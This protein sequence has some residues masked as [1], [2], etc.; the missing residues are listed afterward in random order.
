[1]RN[2]VEYE[3]VSQD[4]S[5]IEAMVTSVWETLTG[6]S[7]HAASPQKLFIQWVTS[8]IV[9][10][11]ANINYAANQNIPSRAEGENL[12]ALGELFYN[13]QR[14]QAKY[15]HTTIRVYISEAQTVQVLIPSGTRF[16]TTDGAVVF[17]T[18]EDLYV[19]PGDIYIDVPA[20]CSVAGTTGNGY[21]P[22][23]INTCVDV[24]NLYQSCSNITTTDG[25]T[26]IATDDEYYDVLVASMDAHSTAGASASY[27]YWSKQVSN[28]ILD[29]CV[30][31]PTP[32]D[33]NIY[34]IMS[35]GSIA[36]EEMKTAIH[37]A[38]NSDD[39]RPLT[40]H[41]YVED[42]EIVEYDVDLTYYLSSD[43]AEMSA[44][45]MQAKVEEVVGEYNLWQAS[46]IGRDINPSKLIHMLMEAGVKRVDVTSPVFTRLRSGT[47]TDIDEGH[48]VPQLA[49][50]RNINIVSGGYEDE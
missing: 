6:Q 1:M 33:V 17:S 37:A 11:R 14:P 47:Q 24:F 22:G 7:V 19:Q 16:T 10:L 20:V 8:I 46:R 44:V 49:Q 34:A 40:D 35:D 15:A 42:P 27:E 28:D 23:Q 36:S 41:V 13:L 43:E 18:S 29:I 30:N 45:E 38:C 31:S 50:I 21:T 5:T 4:E 12:D 2:S 48:P 32:G 9:Q 39:V 3:F 26:D 25:G